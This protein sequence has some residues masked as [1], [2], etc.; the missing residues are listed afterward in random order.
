MGVCDEFLSLLTGYEFLETLVLLQ[1]EI[2]DF[3][4]TLLNRGGVL[5]KSLSK[6][7]PQGY[8]AYTWE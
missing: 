8:I 4:Y 1:T 3:P 7:V 6:G 2:R 5:C